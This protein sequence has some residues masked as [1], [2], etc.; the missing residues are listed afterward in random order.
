MIDWARFFG[1]SAGT[2]EAWRAE[3]RG[4]IAARVGRDV[5]SLAAPVMVSRY[6]H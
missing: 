3:M 2:F 4:V 5:R 6:F 1:S